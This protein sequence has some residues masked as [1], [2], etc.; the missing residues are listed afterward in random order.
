ML[1]STIRV[2]RAVEA[3]IRR[4]V[5]RHDR[6]RA[7]DGDL[8]LQGSLVFLLGRPAIVE[9]LALDRLEATGNVRARAAQ[10]G[11]FA[12]A[13]FLHRGATLPSSDGQ[14]YACTV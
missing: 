3:D 11:G 12:F 1:A 2:D 4:V 14:S 9:G 6:A 7:L 13:V 8:R 10:E 5:V